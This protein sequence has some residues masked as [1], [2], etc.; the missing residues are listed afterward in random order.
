MA[1]KTFGQHRAASYAYIVEFDALPIATFN[2]VSGIGGIDVNMAE[3][4]DS[5][6]QIHEVPMRWKNKRISL[7]APIEA[8]ELRILYLL[9]RD[10]SPRNGA[11]IIRDTTK[12]V[13][14]VHAF[15]GGFITTSGADGGDRESDGFIMVNFELTVDEWLS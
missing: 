2:N 11:I 5:D 4:T 12:T 10:K 7:G 9:A 13:I 3:A 15:T 8:A 6:G 14:A 1:T